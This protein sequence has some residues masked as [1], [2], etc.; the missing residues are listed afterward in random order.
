MGANELMPQSPSRVLCSHDY[1]GYVTSWKHSNNLVAKWMV[2][3]KLNAYYS[4]I[5]YNNILN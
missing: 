3:L 1:E 5:T 4:F 2:K